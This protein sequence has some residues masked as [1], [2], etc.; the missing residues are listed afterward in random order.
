MRTWV[1]LIF[2][3]QGSSVSQQEMIGNVNVENEEMKDFYAA[4]YPP[5]ENS[6]IFRRNTKVDQFF[7]FPNAIC[8]V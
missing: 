7:K 1:F 6:I 8:Q 3:F 5:K 4:K 2:F